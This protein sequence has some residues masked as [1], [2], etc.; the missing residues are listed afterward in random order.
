MLA[1]QIVDNTKYEKALGLL[2][3]MGGMF[4]TRPTHVLLIGETQY[5][6]LVQAGLVEP[7]GAEAPHRGKKKKK[8]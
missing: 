1:V 8:V 6:A 5:R 2:Y 7:N 3:R 4:R